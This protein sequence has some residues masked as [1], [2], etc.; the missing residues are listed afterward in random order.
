MSSVEIWKE[1]LLHIVIRDAESMAAFVDLFQTLH[2][3]PNAIGFSRAELKESH[4]ELIASIME[5][6]QIQDE[7]S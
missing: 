1:E 5:Y 6:I 7:P 4:R 3:Q 2:T